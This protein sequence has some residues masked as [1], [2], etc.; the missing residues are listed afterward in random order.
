VVYGLK[1][2][3]KKYNDWEERFL[4][5]IRLIMN[6]LVDMEKLK[7]QFDPDEKVSYDKYKLAV[8]GTP[9]IFIRFISSFFLEKDE[10]IISMRT[11]VAIDYEKMKN[12]GNK[13]GLAEIPVYHMFC[14]TFNTK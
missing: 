12:I 9:Y 6:D 7:A 3:I 13:L 14:Q 5:L 8:L 1:F 4:Q 11:M 10:D 2:L